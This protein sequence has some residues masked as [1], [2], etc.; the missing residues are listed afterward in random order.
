M[1][2]KI[3]HALHGVKIRQ[4]QRGCQYKKE[5]RIINVFRQWIYAILLCTEYGGTV[6]LY[7]SKVKVVLHSIEI[8]KRVIPDSSVL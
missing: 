4:K 6:S 7:C 1:E 3:K 8:N 5:K 2:M